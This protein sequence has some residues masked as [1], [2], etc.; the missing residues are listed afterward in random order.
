MLLSHNVEELRAFLNEKANKAES[1]RARLLTDFTNA[2]V[3]ALGE[4]VRNSNTT[5][6]MR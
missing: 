4:Y 5:Q 1:V 2:V 6:P 3:G